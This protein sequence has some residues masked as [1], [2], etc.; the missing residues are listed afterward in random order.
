MCRPLLP[1]KQMPGGHTKHPRSAGGRA[2]RPW[3]WAV[4]ETTQ[5]I[6]RVRTTSSRET[7]P[8]PVRLGGKSGERLAVTVRGVAAFLNA[9]QEAMLGFVEVVAPASLDGDGMRAFTDRVWAETNVFGASAPLFT[10]EEQWFRR[11]L[12]R[13]GARILV[14]AAGRGREVRW[15]AAQGYEVVAFEP[16]ARFQE[17]LARS[18]AATVLCASYEELARSVPSEIARLAPYD[19]VLFGWGSFSCLL[20]EDDRRA[21]LRLASE[22]TR[23]GPI[24][25]SFMMVPRTV[26]R[27]RAAGRRVARAL[28]WPGRIPAGDRLYHNVGFL[29]G[30]DDSEFEDLAQSCGLELSAPLQRTF[31]YPHVTLLR[32]VGNS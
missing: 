22:L 27:S 19:A 28:G 17:E 2:S 21:A 6:A 16:V 18:G 5:S 25:V 30:F 32:R 4:W 11:D 14:G 12:P 9:L 29:H 7:S 24:L 8:L 23:A 10:W 15:L 1:R 31:E 3:R 13:P 20:A 26:G